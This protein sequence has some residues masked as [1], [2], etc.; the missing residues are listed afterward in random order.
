M[1]HSIARQIAAVFIGL[2]LLVLA[3]AWLRAEGGTLLAR[4]PALL[5]DIKLTLPLALGLYLLFLLRAW[6]K[7]V[8]REALLAA[9]ALGAAG[10]L[11]IAVFFFAVYFPAR[12][13]CPFITYT[14]LADALLLSEL[15]E[16]KA[17]VAHTLLAAGLILAMLAVLPAAVQDVLATYRQSMERDAY[18]RW[19]EVHRPDEVIYVEPITPR[20]KYSA[21]WPGDASYFD[22][23]ISIFYHLYRFHV[24]E[25]ID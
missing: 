19:A 10:I 1:K 3:A 13:A 25:Y 21:C 23:D 8:R 2:M 18:L 16:K 24:T 11:S 15:W 9:L 4:L 6:E 12:S 5:N 14:T 20:T 7:G 22:E 17:P